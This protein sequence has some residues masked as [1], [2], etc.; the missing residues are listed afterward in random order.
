MASRSLRTA[1]RMAT[2]RIILARDTPITLQPACLPS[3]L[4]SCQNVQALAITS[5]HA[6]PGLSLALNRG[7]C[8]HLTQLHI[9][10]ET[11]DSW[12]WDQLS[13]LALAI[14]QGTLPQLEVLSV[15]PGLSGKPLGQLLEMLKEGR[16]SP[17]LR[18]MH[19]HTLA[20]ENLLVLSQT[21]EG[22]DH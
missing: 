18:E 20:E 11:Y 16:V 14:G 12:S 1:Y 7:A 8:Q 17:L 9:L 2:T 15:G 3:L 19:F 6:L 10:P 5:S 21:L 13:C 4:E 22:G